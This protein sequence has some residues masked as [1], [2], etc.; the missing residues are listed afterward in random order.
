MWLLLCRINYKATLVPCIY[1]L[2]KFIIA[3]VRLQHGSTTCAVLE[4]GNLGVQLTHAPTFTNK[5]VDHN[6]V[7]EA[8][9]VLR[10]KKKL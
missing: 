7:K 2:T 9:D 8:L 6:V 1:L 4:K 5:F 10:L 3:G